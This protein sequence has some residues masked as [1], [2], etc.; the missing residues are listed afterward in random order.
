MKR[1][2][3]KTKMLS[4]N[5]IVNSARILATSSYL[6][7]ALSNYGTEKKFFGRT[8]PEVSQNFDTLITPKGWAFS[9]WAFIFLGEAL[10]FVFVWSNS[11]C[12]KEFNSILVP[13]MYACLLQSLWCVS[14]SREQIF[15]SALSLSGIAY[16]LKACTDEIFEIAISGSTSKL[17]S[18]SISLIT[19]PIR[20][21]FAWTT[22][23]ML[24]NWNM[25]VV[26][27][28]IPGLEVLPAVLSVWIG[29]GIGTFRAI[30][31]GDA[32]F[33]SVL[34]WAFTAMSAKI[35]SSPPEAFSKDISFLEVLIL[36]LE[37]TCN[38]VRRQ[39]LLLRTI[40]LAFLF[41]S[42]TL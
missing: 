22:A 25:L 4:Q 42:V 2:E 28:K 13:F 34:A 10:G 18:L 32:I 3:S 29:A 26:S 41:I 23:A 31:L 30:F 35:R 39:L 11:N 1:K 33:S 14:F 5:Q 9:I 37:Y 20:M 15:T 17:S 36:A 24:I 40:F 27:F 8:N 38:C 7:N 21:H 6:I 12:H 19:Y 16:C